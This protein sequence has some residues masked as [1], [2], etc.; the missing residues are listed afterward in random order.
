MTVDELMREALRLK[1]TDRASMAHELLNSLETLSEAELEQ[2][3]VEEAL[4]RSAEIDAGI[5][6]AI[7]ADEVI[8]QARA[9]L[10]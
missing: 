2:L 6:E 9:R 10:K 8:A 5:V 3:W 1:A 7:P 4:R